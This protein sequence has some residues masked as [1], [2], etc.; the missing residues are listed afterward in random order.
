LK[1]EGKHS[2]NFFKNANNKTD[3]KNLKSKIKKRKFPFN[4]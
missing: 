1:K 4:E 3:A 2:A